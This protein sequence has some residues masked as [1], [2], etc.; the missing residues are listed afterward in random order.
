MGGEDAERVQ[1]HTQASR[2]PTDPSTK[3][4]NKKYMTTKLTKEQ[5][6]AY[7]LVG[8]IGGLATAKKKGKKYMKEIGKRGGLKRWAKK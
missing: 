7:A 5:K 1:A 4:I 2:N 3:N 6:A 8:R